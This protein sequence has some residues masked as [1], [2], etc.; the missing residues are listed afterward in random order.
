MPSPH[1]PNAHSTIARETFH[2][3]GA[4]ELT[5]PAAAGRMRQEPEQA[6]KTALG[7]AVTL[8]PRRAGRLAAGVGDARVLGMDICILLVSC[9]IF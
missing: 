1:V 3:A 4:E 5:T 7:A 6:A 8:G 9:T 2:P